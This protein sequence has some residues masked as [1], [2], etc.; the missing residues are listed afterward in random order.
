MLTFIITLIILVAILLVLV[1]LAQNSKGGGLTSQ[2]GGSGASQIVGVKRTGDIL[3]K[4]TWVLAISL[5]VLSLTSSIVIK[6]DRSAGGYTSPNMEKVQDES[7]LPGMDQNNEQLLPEVGV[8]TE[9]EQPTI[10]AT[11]ESDSVE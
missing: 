1:V 7:I 3:E 5:V 9:G 4:I 2:F 11:E 6:S 8:E 10:E